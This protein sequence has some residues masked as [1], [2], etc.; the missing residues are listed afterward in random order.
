MINMF[1]DR[2]CIAGGQ[3]NKKTA[4]AQDNRGYSMHRRTQDMLQI[5]LIATLRNMTSSP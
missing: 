4:G 5:F 1:I 2:Q 3:Q